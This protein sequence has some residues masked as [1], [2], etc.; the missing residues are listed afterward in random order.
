MRLLDLYYLVKP[1]IPHG[2]RLRLRQLGAVRLRRRFAESW[3]INQAASATPDGWPGWPQGKQFAFVITHDV[4][5]TKGMERCRRLAEMEMGLGFRSSF[6]FVPEGEY[7][8]PASLRSFLHEHG[9]EV[10]V[11]DLHHDGSLYRSEKTFHEQARQINHHLEAWNAVGFRAGFMFH[12]LQWLQSLNV[13]Y[14]ASTFDTDPFEPQPDSVNSIFPFWVPRNNDTGFVELPYTLPQDSTLY[15][16]LRETDNSIWKRKLDWVAENGGL[17]LVNV[18]PDYIAFDNCP[19][20]SEYREDLY[21]DFLQ[22]V[23]DRYASTAWMALPREVAQ[24][25]AAD[26][27]VSRDMQRVPLKVQQKTA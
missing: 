2:V 26:R 8:T 21:R 27:N 23:Q 24:H 6:N 9:F 12:N 16:V 3:P 19:S 11:H 15:L 17:A 22:Y 25:V 18:H 13:L 14:D 20:S 5:G 4:E 1:A 10:G 7:E